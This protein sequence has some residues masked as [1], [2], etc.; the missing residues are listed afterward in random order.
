MGGKE[1][2]SLPES[3][4]YCERKV[5]KLGKFGVQIGEVDRKGVEIKNRANP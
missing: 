4:I 3:G 2:T 5:G 1:E